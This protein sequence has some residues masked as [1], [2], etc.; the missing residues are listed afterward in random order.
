MTS[1]SQAQVG[2]KKTYSELDNSNASYNS[3]IS[4]NVYSKPNYTSKPYSK[5]AKALNTK[6]RSQTSDSALKHRN[7]NLMYPKG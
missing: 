5:S 2:H 3:T 4:Q 7:F 6:F 1:N